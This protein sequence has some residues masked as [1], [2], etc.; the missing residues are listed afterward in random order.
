VQKKKY[1]RA[2]ETAGNQTG[3]ARPKFEG[4][5]SITFHFS[6]NGGGKFVNEVS[7]VLV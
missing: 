4:A 1:R 2:E 6:V 7:V 3:P 5:Y